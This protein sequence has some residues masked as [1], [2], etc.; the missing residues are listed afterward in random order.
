M[1]GKMMGY[2]RDLC[3]IGCLLCILCMYLC[4]YIGIETYIVRSGSMEPS[5][6][7][8][9]IC[10]IDTRFDY[11]DIK[12]D[13]VIAF[14]R[15]KIKVTH[16]VIKVT[17]EGFITKGDNNT[18]SDGLTT[19]KDNYIGKNICS[20]PW[21]GYIIAFLQTIKGKIISVTLMILILLLR[22]IL[23]SLNR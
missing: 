2:I 17:K 1:Y 13:D 3:I 18:I 9:S 12:E 11:T 8:G 16:R 23:N 19:T 6:M 4:K 5:I 22:E 14:E 15:G 21:V 10:F 20:I 7:T